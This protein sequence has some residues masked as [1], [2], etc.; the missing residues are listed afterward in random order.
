MD[1][2]EVCNAHIHISQSL[3][4]PLCF[5]SLKS[6]T[7]A[8]TINHS[9]SKQYSFNLVFNLSV[10]LVFV[11]RVQSF[12]WAVHLTITEVLHLMHYFC[13]LSFIYCIFIFTLQYCG[14]F[15]PKRWSLCWAGLYDI[16]GSV[17]TSSHEP[18]HVV[19]K[20]L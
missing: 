11:K 12:L 9:I 17:T 14:R 2:L 4:V 16:T 6:H 13:L 1:M 19:Q 15:R 10:Q 5:A 7:S 18:L 8:Y 3:C 20:L